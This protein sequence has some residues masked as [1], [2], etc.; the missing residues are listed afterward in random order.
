MLLD[1]LPLPYREIG[2]RVIA[3]PAQDRVSQSPKP[4]EYSPTASLLLIGNFPVGK[5]VL[6]EVV[7]THLTNP[8]FPICDGTSCTLSS[9]WLTPFACDLLVHETTVLSPIG[10]SDFAKLKC[11]E[12]TLAGSPILR[13]PMPPVLLYCALWP[14]R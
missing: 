13:S 12:L 10:N 14:T 3:S 4:D 5:S 2:T 1:D 7:I 11:V 8:R 9:L 6:Y